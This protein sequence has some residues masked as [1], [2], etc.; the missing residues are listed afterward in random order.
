MLRVMRLAEEKVPKPELARFYLQLLDN[1]HN[2]LPALYRVLGDL[3]MVEL[4]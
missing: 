2:S 3:C 4:G 1:R